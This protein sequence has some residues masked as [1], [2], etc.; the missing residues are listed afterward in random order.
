MEWQ[1]IRQ[2]SF[3]GRLLGYTVYYYEYPSYYVSHRS[4][5]IIGPDVHMTV[6]SGLKAAQR[7]RVSVAGFSSNGVGPK[8]SNKEIQTGNSIIILT[9]FQVWPARPKRSQMIEQFLVL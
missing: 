6:L 5:N 1:P 2:H 3:K 8:T 4:V 9:P 7:Y